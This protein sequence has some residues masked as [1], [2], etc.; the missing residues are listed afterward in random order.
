MLSFSDGKIYD[1]YVIYPRN[2]KDSPEAT[3]SVDY[4]VHQILPDVLENE[5]GYNLCIHGRDLLPG[6]GNTINIHWGQ[7]FTSSE[8]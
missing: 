3:S 7:K 5:C 2:H 8:G 1:A 4:F 6:G